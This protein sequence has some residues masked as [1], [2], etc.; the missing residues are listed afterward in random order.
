MKYVFKQRIV[1]VSRINQPGGLVLVVAHEPQLFALYVR[2]LEPEF[3]VFG[4]SD[5]QLLV[6]DI[7]RH[8]PDIVLLNIDA[9]TLGV[10]AVQKVTRM[11][12]L[13]KVVTTSLSADEAIMREVMNAGVSGHINRTL[14]RP[15]DVVVMV[16]QALGIF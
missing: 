16:K 14:T 5:P 3:K 9:P 11:F 1:T 15:Q 6:T 13:L 7:R 12:P 8:V 10:P 4:S 2:H